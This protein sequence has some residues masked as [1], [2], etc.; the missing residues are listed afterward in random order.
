MG[1]RVIRVMAILA[2]LVCAAG[3]SL[4]LADSS[5]DAVLYRGSSDLAGLNVPVVTRFGARPV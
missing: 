2:L 1:L 4:P 5:I 3:E